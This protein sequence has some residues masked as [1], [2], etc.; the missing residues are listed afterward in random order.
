MENIQENFF[1]KNN[2]SLLN[3]KL[4]ENLN[5]KNLN[6]KQRVFIA[7][8]IVNNMKTTWK[9][10]N[11]SKIRPDNFQSV[12]S[13][14]NSIVYE[15]SF[16]K[17]KKLITPK[18]HENVVSDPISKKFER[19]F[20]SNPNNGVTIHDRPISIT[21]N[22][23]SWIDPNDQYVKTSQEIYN[24]AGQP[25]RNLDNLFRPIVDE[26]SEETQF[27]N[28][29]VG[30]GDNFKEKLQD[31]ARMRETE[32][33]RSRKEDIVLPDF[34]KPKATSVRFQEDF[35][36]KINVNQ[37]NKKQSNIQ[38]NDFNF[39]DGADDDE[40]LCSL[41]NIDK[42][43]IND[44]E[45]EEDQLS[46]TDRLNN[47]KNERENVQIPKQKS[48]N[49]NNIQPTRIDKLKSKNTEK[50]HKKQQY[51]D[52]RRHEYETKPNQSNKLTNE[53][54]EL[55][56][57]LISLNKN[58]MSQLT[59]YKND[60]DQLRHD[61][62]ELAEKLQEIIHKEELLKGKEKELNEKYDTIIN[63]KKFQ[64]E[65]NTESSKS[66]YRYNFINT[67]NISGIKLTTCSIPFKK[68]NIEHDINN[69]FLYTI[70]N[71]EKNITLTEGYYTI[72]EIIENLNLNQTDLVFELNSINQKI[73]I[74]SDLK[75][76]IVPTTLS[77]L[78]LG[79]KSNYNNNNIYNADTMY[80]LRINNK[81]YLFFKNISDEP[82]SIITPNTNIYDSELLFENPVKLNYLDIMFK[83]ENDN[84]YNFYNISHYIHLQLMT[85]N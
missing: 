70:N 60:N 46:F 65:I 62:L 7:Q 57:K 32:I 14:F 50:N 84:N 78:N 81:V 33:P 72:Q 48:V 83:D 77:I 3:N 4:L 27:N 69:L 67:L 79:F 35:S 16:D 26:I 13:Q 64:L 25:D 37:E 52:K 39:I 36:E 2:I 82:I 74:I 21:Q 66:N 63:V 75:F 20:K 73:K 6:E 24:L 59:L 12:L 5:I 55:F 38:N 11:I 29:N 80:D 40:N 56:D 19:D 31:I 30:R 34:L 15:N 28:Y 45:Y 43:L 61:N 23:N 49:F 42:P 68:Y 41:D 1:S 17:I 76:N 85:T 22:N 9:T 71:I 8:T 58:L 10:I 44:N 54:R 18:M 47:L 51:E 53:K